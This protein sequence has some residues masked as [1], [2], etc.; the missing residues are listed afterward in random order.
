ME[1]FKFQ[2]KRSSHENNKENLDAIEFIKDKLG[3]ESDLV[4]ENAEVDENNN[5]IKAKIFWVRFPSPEKLR[6]NPPVEGKVYL[7]EQPNGRLIV[8]APGSPGG[9]AGS[10][11]RKHAKTL[12]EAGNTLITIRHNGQGV[13]VE[14]T[15]V[16]FNSPERVAMMEG[17]DQTYL[18]QDVCDK[19]DGY[20]W[21]DITSE[22]ITPI[23]DAEQNFERISLIGHSLGATS[24]YRSVGMLAETHPE[25][26][27]KIEKIIS[28]AG[29]LGKPEETEQGFWHG[30]KWP[31]EKLVDA[32]MADAVEDH[33]HIPT[34]R[35][36]FKQSLI[37]TAKE[38]AKLQIPEH[39]AQ[40]LVTSPYDAAIAMPVI[41]YTREADGKEFA[42]AYDY[43]GHQRKSL[44]I[45]DYT[46]PEK[47]THK[48]TMLMH[49]PTLL[50]LL[51]M[52]LGRSPH[53]VQVRSKE[54]KEK[55]RSQKS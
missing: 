10:F 23:L 6:A 11:E 8:F 18:G 26:A 4:F 15:P 13:G 22:P 25:V 53:F 31:L 34:D 40:I 35:D 1:N 33:V 17:A 7:P 39:I 12:V 5:E 3:F 52:R 47:K 43:P 20:S 37:E 46:P 29:Y 28:L 2:E 32:E 50:R 36:K 54:P 41:K 9:D 16:I 44:V 38:L 48:Q 24:I 27:A 45:E 42:Q 19:P 49:P 51:N 30:T 55:L 14:K 21:L